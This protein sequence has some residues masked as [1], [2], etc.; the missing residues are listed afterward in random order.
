MDK[1]KSIELQ[2]AE[3]TDLL[4]YYRD[5][6]DEG[7]PV[8]TDAQYDALYF[9][10]LNLEKKY[11]YSLVKSPTRT[12]STINDINFRKINH[13]VPMLSLKKTKD[14]N[15]IKSLFK[16]H[17][18]VAMCKLDG[19]TVALTY[20][21]GYLTRAETRGNGEV[22][23]D[24]TLNVINIYN[25]PR[26]IKT[27]VHTMIVEGEI[28]STYENF[29]QF[30]NEFDNP[31]NFAAGSLKLKNP[32]ESA[33]RGL[34]FWAW[35]I[36]L[37]YKGK[38]FVDKL[39]LLRALG[40]SVVPFSIDQDSKD[41]TN[42]LKDI[43]EELSLPID[44]IV[45]KYNDIQYG[46]SLGSTEHHANN[47][48]AF[49][50]Y[51]E[52]YPTTIKKIEYSVGRSGVI[53]PVAVI[54]PVEIEGATISRCNL[55]NVTFME[56]LLGN[57]YKGQKVYI[58]RRNKV[59]PQIE[60]AED[61]GMGEL[62]YPR[63][64]PACGTPTIFKPKGDGIVEFLYC[65]NKHCSA[66]KLSVF[67]HF[68][69]TDFMNIKNLG[70][71]TLN[72]FIEKG[73]INTLADIYRLEK[74]RNEIIQLPGFGPRTIDK[75]LNYIDESRQCTPAL[76]LASIGIPRVGKV[77]AQRIMNFFTS[78]Q[79]F[80]DKVKNNFDFTKI[81]G[82][83]DNLNEALLTFDYTEADETAQYLDFITQEEIHTQTKLSNKVFVITGTLSY[84]K[85]RNEL[86]QAI[87][88][89]GAVVSN[90]VTNKTN[91]VIC[92]NSKSNSTKMIRARELNV[93]IITEEEFNILKSDK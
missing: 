69:S 77:S 84:Y 5:K 90:T 75:I 91:Y 92:N 34:S 52:T 31:R 53:T 80:R 1:D 87:K 48:I 61:Y 50:F 29:E 44:G 59:I 56:L 35:E 46:E 62:E 57:P 60:Y 41:A 2:I 68:A 6:Y 76:F 36:G 30:K 25:I 83:N 49:K 70:E 37:G 89:M 85:N 18:Y 8:I 55:H 67:T 12:I 20:E 4:L 21:D 24:V 13:A 54:E 73:Y 58:S 11:N 93:P 15:V 45:Y 72:L 39:E 17:D 7:N 16:E 28:L 26:F 82:I 88:N 33:K 81:D 47:A 10:L 40:F 74:H 66:Q 27:D 86:I 43:A 3:L 51:D 65:P 63:E 79:D 78:Y 9:K 32:V 23:E 14:Y 42:I 38:F 19:L 64:C 22:G 71:A